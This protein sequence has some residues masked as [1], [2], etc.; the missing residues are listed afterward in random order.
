[1]AEIYDSH[2]VPLIFQQYADDLAARTAAL[3][4]ESL[5]EIAA[6]SGVVTR[7]V[8]PVLARGAR[9]VVTDLNPPMLA[10][11]VSQQPDAG[12]LEW[13]VADA[14]D[15]P[16]DQDTFD[17]A[18]CQFGAMFF[19][20][21][22]AAYREARRVLRPGGSFIFSMWDRIEENEFADEVTRA[23][24]EIFPADQP[25]FLARTPH[26]HH[27]PSR[28]Q[29]ELSAAGFEEISV[30]AADGRSVAPDPR[31]PAV[32]YCQGTPLRSET[33]AQSGPGLDEVTDYAAK[34]IA[35]HFGRDPVEGRIR[36]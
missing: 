33:E 23:T 6:G 34:A 35:D 14:Q 11:A 29:A 26:G 19:P 18:L 7:A 32:A 5:L 3:E 22:V 30:L 12:H 15:L 28:Y 31:T 16:F 20:D 24:A 1:M 13:G 25:Q 17:L 27:D 10:K 8:A 4:P 21:R 2:L 36:A 9:Y